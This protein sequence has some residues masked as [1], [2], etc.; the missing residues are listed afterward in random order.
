MSA[1]LGPVGFASGS[2]L[3]LG[4]EEVSSRAYADDTQKVI[5]EEVADLE[6]LTEGVGPHPLFNGVRRAT[7][8]GLARPQIERAGGAV[9]VRAPGCT[10]RFVSA[11]AEVSRRQVLVRLRDA[12]Q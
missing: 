5:D 4:N 7:V 8:A 1:R 6:T 11:V 10:A 2:P 12:K 3:Y 9:T